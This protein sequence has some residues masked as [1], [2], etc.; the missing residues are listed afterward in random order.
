MIVKALEIRDAGTFIPAIAINT[1]GD[2]LEQRYLLSRSGYAS[3]GRTIIVLR[4][5]DC[6]AS[7]D[8]YGYEVRDGTMRVAHI[9][10]E[11]HFDEL[12]DGDVIDV[13]FIAGIRSTSKVSE[14]LEHPS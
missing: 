3:H 11:K 9:Y 8:P 10:I 5:A 6:G 2:N 12:R 4:L 7:Y 13:E 1:V 14:R